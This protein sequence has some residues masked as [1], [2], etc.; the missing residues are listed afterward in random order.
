MPVF[1]SPVFGISWAGRRD[2]MS[3][4]RFKEF[5]HEWFLKHPQSGGETYTRHLFF[6][7]TQGT[8]IVI[9]GLAL[10]VHGLVPK[11]FEKTA[12]MRTFKTYDLFKS[13]MEKFYKEKEQEQDKLHAIK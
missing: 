2:R 3:V 9:T 11:F 7:L 12:S 4:P 5:I 1:R 10:I 13:R 6:T 8:Y